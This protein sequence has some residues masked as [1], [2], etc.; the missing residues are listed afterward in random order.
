MDIKAEV[1]ALWAVSFGTL[2]RMYKYY[3]AQRLR[4]YLCNRFAE[5]ECKDKNV[6]KIYC[7]NTNFMKLR[8]LDE[9]EVSTSREMILT[10]GYFGTLWGAD[11]IVDNKISKFKLE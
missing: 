1:K 5:I 2:G 8:L 4:N 6:T 9:M 7:N 3:Q 11:V 10:K